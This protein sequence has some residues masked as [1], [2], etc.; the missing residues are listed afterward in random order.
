MEIKEIIN[1]KNINIEYIGLGKMDT[2]DKNIMRKY[3]LEI[4]GEKFNYFE[5]L[6]LEEL[7]AENK[8]EKITSALACIVREYSCLDYCNSVDSFASEYGYEDLEQ[9]EE[10]FNQIL[11]NNAKLEKV[12]THNEIYD[13]QDLTA[14]I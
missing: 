13:L 6:G 5:G 1:G 7:T 11:E 2:L 3:Q 9:A 4:N 10:I 8:E 12:L 14:E